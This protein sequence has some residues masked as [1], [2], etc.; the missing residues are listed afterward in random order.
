MP[1][2]LR[3]TWTYVFIVVNQVTGAILFYFISKLPNAVALCL[4]R[5]EPIDKEEN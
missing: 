3:S 2:N 4:N 1:N 5:V